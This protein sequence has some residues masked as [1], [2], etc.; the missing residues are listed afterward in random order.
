MFLETLQACLTVHSLTD[1][2]LVMFALNKIK[3]R[4][5]Y[6]LLYTSSHKYDIFLLAFYQKGELKAQAYISYFCRRFM[7]ICQRKRNNNNKKGLRQLRK[8]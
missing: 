8:L 3:Y 2:F 1:L 6:V 7:F 5:V 4:N